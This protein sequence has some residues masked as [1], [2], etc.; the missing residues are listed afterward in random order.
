MNYKRF[1]LTAATVAVILLGAAAPT[2][3]AVLAMTSSRSTF[4]TWGT[5]TTIDFES[6][7][8]APGGYVAYTFDAGG[9]TLD[10]VNFKFFDNGVNTLRAM[11]PNVGAAEN[12]GTGHV[13]KG[14][15]TAVGSYLLVTLPTS[16]TMFGVDLGVTP[17][18]VRTFSVSLDGVEAATGIAAT[19]KPNFTFF[20]L[21]SDTP[22]SQVK[23]YLAGSGG[24]IYPIMDNFSYMTAPPP[25]PPPV[26]N[27]EVAT[28]LYVA[29]GLGL[30]GWRRRRASAA[31]A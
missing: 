16:V 25:P 20:G 11:L 8:L 10:G 9:L 23:I 18:T 28:L 21:S 31:Q 15:G 19:I 27:A 29:T 12:F 5:A 30:I 3:A 7:N 1:F 26:E 22:F 24:N 14:F 13:L 6:L 17:S 2:S 4:Y